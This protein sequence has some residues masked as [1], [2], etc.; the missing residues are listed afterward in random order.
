[1]VVP[2]VVVM[3]VWLAGL[4]V[5]LMVAKWGVSEVVMTVVTRVVELVRKT[6]ETMVRKRVVTMVA[7]LVALSAAQ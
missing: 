5:D 6:V 3:V 4:K 1:M 7:N 2:M